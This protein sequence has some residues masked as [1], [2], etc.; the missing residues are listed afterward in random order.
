MP[1]VPGLWDV[2]GHGVDTPIAELADE[3]LRDQQR[4][5]RVAIDAAGLYAAYEKH[6]P[7][8]TRP[9][10]T[11]WER[12]ETQILFRLADLINRNVCPILVF[13]GSH[14]QL[15]CGFTLARFAILRELAEKLGVRCLDAR[16]ESVAEC[17]KL[18][19]LGYV[20]AVWSE[21]GLAFLYGATRVVRE[22][23]EAVLEKRSSL[24]THFVEDVDESYSWLLRHT[25]ILYA[26]LVGGQYG[27]TRT[28]GVQRC[29]PNWALLL[30]TR[31]REAL[32]SRAWI[33][34]SAD[35]SE[36][37][38]RTF[39]KILKVKAP[40]ITLPCNFPS[41]S[42][43]KMFD[44]SRAFPDDHFEALFNGSM[45]AG[46]MID[47]EGLNRSMRRE[48]NLCNCDYLGRICPAILNSK[49]QPTVPKGE[50]SN[51]SLDFYCGPA[52]IAAA[53][54]TPSTNT[55]AGLPIDLVIWFKARS[56]S[57]LDI[58]SCGNGDCHEGGA[59]AVLDEFVQSSVLTRV[60]HEVLLANEFE[61]LAA[62]VLPEPS[63]APLSAPPLSEGPLVAAPLSKMNAE[64]NDLPKRLLLQKQSDV[65]V[66]VSAHDAH[67]TGLPG[68]LLFL[69]DQAVDERTSDEKDRRH[70]NAAFTCRSNQTA[71]TDN[72]EYDS[73]QRSA[74]SS[75]SAGSSSSSASTSISTSATSISTT[76]ASSTV[77][78]PSASSRSL[79]NVNNNSQR[80]ARSKSPQV[81]LQRGLL[82][83]EERAQF[84]PVQ[85]TYYNVRN[86]KGQFI[87]KQAAAAAA[88]RKSVSKA[89]KSKSAKHKSVLAARASGSASESNPILAS[90]ATVKQRHKSG[91]ANQSTLPT[92]PVAHRTKR[93]K[94]DSANGSTV[95]SAPAAAPGDTIR[96]RSEPYSS[97]D[98]SLN[99][100][101]P[102]AAFDDSDTSRSGSRP[103]SGISAEARSKRPSERQKDGRG[104]RELSP[105]S[106][107]SYTGPVE[108]SGGVGDQEGDEAVA[109]PDET[110]NFTHD[111]VFE[112]R[113]DFSPRFEQSDADLH[114]PYP[115][116]SGSHSA[117]GQ[118]ARTTDQRPSVDQDDADLALKRRLSDTP[119]KPFWVF[120]IIGTSLASG[121]FTT[122][123]NNFPN[124]DDHVTSAS[125]LIP[126]AVA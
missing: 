76:P 93:L 30:V 47:E 57:N 92:A 124:A 104:G 26:Y 115:A 22:T 23:D 14:A 31:Y 45:Q 11:Y 34:T 21:E 108:M 107:E 119:A 99:P 39:T 106:M 69:L 12:T 15:R 54:Q 117:A 103:T 100:L 56:V 80:D 125:D 46:L 116:Q 27:I 1:F 52:S 55:Y 101:T 19:V 43:T 66:S 77:K 37:Q 25:S 110:A 82:S 38:E 35:V 51:L 60:L 33:D 32:Q 85:E 48:L 20:D 81:V 73:S 68:Q 61:T 18:Q 28:H 79:D 112:R 44:N 5:F 113:N 50:R 120:G 63:A 40:H 49:L 84:E 96:V 10:D 41:G 95:P 123:N 4:P 65:S 78:P 17:A 71:I 24:R 122:A 2:V 118:S 9:A 91:N 105:V 98:S 70:D 29:G 109:V 114:D 126:A 89:P 42:A 58:K 94:T 90:V 88:K 13:E 6:P 83:A 8:V 111:F 64:T 36:I 7:T 3:T 59:P 86:S 74:T 121:T 87:S 16:A 97:G 67:S 62:L 102:P 53:L 75:S 72:G